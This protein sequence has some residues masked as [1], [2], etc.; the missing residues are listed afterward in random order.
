MRIV[1]NIL[2]TWYSGGMT[3]VLASKVNYLAEHGYEVYIITTD[4]LGE[5][6]F[7]SIN[8][9][10]TCIDLNIN[11]HFH[12]QESKF[13]KL[14]HLL[15]KMLRHRRVLSRVL[16]EL[17]AD[18]V[19]SMFAKEALFLPY[20]EDGSKKILEA[21]G[22][23]YTWV[24]TRHGLFG[25]LQNYFDL[26]TIGKF[27]RFVTLTEIDRPNWGSVD[28]MLVIPNPNTFESEQT[29]SL[30]AP[31]VLA[32]GRYHF[33]K[34]F[35]S[36]LKA[37]VIVHRQFPNWLLRLRGEGLDK[38]NP[39]IQEL[40][41]IDCVSIG[42][43]TDMLSEYLE[44]SMFVLSSLWEG[45]PLVLLEAQVCG[46]PLVAYAAQCGPL[47]VITDGENGFLV[48]V[49]NHEALAERMMLLMGSLELRQK[50]GKA[51]KLHSKRFTEDVI[52]KKWEELFKSL[53][54][55]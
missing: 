52:M 27:D 36:L 13:S 24:S 4:Q 28:N 22:A 33:E 50:M 17:K 1:Y 9:K 35:E 6:H 42:S 15:P 5:D 7:Y 18:I 19:V 25:R 46:V 23:R 43:T 55:E 8:D 12:D 45:L 2:N 11:Y 54:H 49:N 21:H 48:E 38:L 31:V 39:L 47:E 3:R 10:V 34:N 40:G 44:C 29:S 53:V 16:K 41:L 32:A 14:F 20:I 30:V 37:W 51:A 26:L